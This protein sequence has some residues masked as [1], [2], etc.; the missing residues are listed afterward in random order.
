MKK[1]LL[2]SLLGLALLFLA[3]V[4]WARQNVDALLDTGSRRVAA[5]LVQAAPGGIAIKELAVT[6]PVFDSGEKT[7]T[8]PGISAVLTLPEGPELLAGR[9]VTVQVASLQLS[10]AELMTRSFVL[11]AD[12]LT[13]TV[14]EEPPG[15]AVANGMAAIRDG[16]LSLPFHLA[17][18]P[19][20][21]TRAQATGLTHD[22]LSLVR[23]G[24]TSLPLSFSAISA[25][26]L[27]GEMVKAALE[28]ERHGS[29]SRLTMN[30][31]SLQILSW[32]LMEKLTDP[33]VELLS[34]N[35]LKAPR[36]LQIRDDAQETANKAHQ[37]RADIPEDAYRHVLW[38]YLLTKAYG[39]EFAKE[40]TDAHEQG[41]TDNSAAEHQMD[42]TNNAV[43]RGYARRDYKRADLVNLLLRDPAVI[44]DPNGLPAK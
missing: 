24:S 12:G 8:W 35:P 17:L 6:P 30:R 16:R 37:E 9:T 38:S 32:L 28:I 33:E 22:L 13:L 2:L 31:E 41:V 14:N 7:I 34:H 42:Y 3:L 20:A 29:E 4:V 25:F 40:V 15:E 26:R 43:G 5:A 11:A 39:Q 23:S 18:W 19:P 36:L 21:V 1:R 27:N 44:R 10:L